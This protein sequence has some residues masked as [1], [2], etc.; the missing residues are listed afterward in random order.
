VCVC[1]KGLFEYITNYT[2]ADVEL[3]S[4]LKPF[5]PD[6]MPAVGE[7]DA[8]VKVCECVSSSVRV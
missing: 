8:F 1:V 5:V 4:V 7:V 6:Y 2:P 3:D